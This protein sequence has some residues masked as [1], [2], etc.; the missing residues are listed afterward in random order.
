MLETSYIL[1]HNGSN[2]NHT[3]EIVGNEE[4]L[5]TLMI[6][7]INDKTSETEYFMLTKC[8]IK[9]M[10]NRTKVK[11]SPRG[12]KQNQENTRFIRHNAPFKS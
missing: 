11:V 3:E 9:N 7:W 2:A 5:S 8:K 12:M 4:H 10:A 1:K 6:E